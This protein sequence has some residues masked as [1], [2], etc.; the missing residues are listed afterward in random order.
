MNNTVWVV[1]RSSQL[2]GTEMLRIYADHQKAR[3]YMETLKKETPYFNYI[4]CPKKLQ[5]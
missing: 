4:I 1:F 2:W 3:K 5:Y